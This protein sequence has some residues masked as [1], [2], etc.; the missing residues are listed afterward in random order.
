V[1]EQNPFALTDESLSH[2]FHLLW[3]PHRQRQLNFYFPSASL[4]NLAEDEKVE[5]WSDSFVLIHCLR[6]ALPFGTHL[7][8]SEYANYLDNSRHNLVDYAQEQLLYWHLARATSWSGHP[9]E[10]IVVCE[11]DTYFWNTHIPQHRASIT[12]ALGLGNPVYYLN[13]F[14]L[15][16]QVIELAFSRL[17][18]ITTSDIN[19]PHRIGVSSGDEFKYTWSDETWRPTVTS[20]DQ[21]LIDPPDFYLPPPYDPPRESLPPSSPPPPLTPTSR[22]HPLPA[23]GIAIQGR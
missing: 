7:T 16:H 10:H 20:S 6:N 11:N 23:R 2:R 17:C 22:P 9:I 3:E 21:P 1:T 14:R 12:R 15:S 13:R 8:R 5:S 4:V 18:L 19:N